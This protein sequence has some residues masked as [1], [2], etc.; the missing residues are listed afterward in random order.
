MKLSR[1]MAFPVLVLLA[2]AVPAAAGATPVTFACDMRIELSFERFTPGVDTLV[3]RGAFNGWSGN[4]LVMTDVDGDDV[5]EI[6][7]DL[8]A[9]SHP[10]KF[11]IPLSTYDRWE[12]F[13]DNRVVTVGGDPVEVAPVFFD[14]RAGWTPG[15]TKCGADISF[16]HQIEAA[17][18]EYRV[19]GVPVNLFEACADHGYEI[20]RLRLWHTPT[21]PWHALPATILMAQ[22][23]KAAGLQFMLDFHYSDTWADPGKQFKPAAWEGIPFAA[24]VDSV[25]AYT[26]A[27]IR[28][29]RDAGA[30]PDY[31]QIGNEV[32]NGMLWD[33]GRVGGAWDTPTQWDNFAALLSAGVA[34]VQDSLSP[35]EQPVIIIHNDQGAGVGTCEWFYDNLVSRGVSF[36]CIG[37]SFYP[38][39]HGDI[40]GLRDNL[41]NLAPRYG[42]EI[43]VV[44][45]A[46]PWTLDW[47]DATNNF[48]WQESQLHANYP[49]TQ[50]GQFGFLR[51]VVAVVEATPGG[52]G[53]GVLYWEPGF[54][55]VDGGPGSPYEN[56]TTFDFDG[57]A[58]PGFGFPMPWSTGVESGDDGPAADDIGDAGEGPG[59]RVMLS[60]AAPN[61]FR[62]SST[63]TLTVFAPGA[64][65]RVR[66]YDVSGRIVTTLTDRE[67][68]PG[69]HDLTWDG[70][71]TSGARVAS[72]V[73]LIGATVAGERATARLVHLK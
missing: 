63:L 42:K 13:V 20:I 48:V 8:A 4:G 55:A 34:G 66:V 52:L 53:T 43:M 37:L 59:S 18:G 44:E 71:D 26:N 22:E 41:E 61:P 27:A 31:V 32:S 25:Y 64:H 60:P 19:D 51:D 23:T 29:F 69:R 15:T 70:R 14:H 68:A 45:T 17:G 16:T 56:L 36:D 54:I 49:A 47:Y 2:L 62:G 12:H 3:V 5:Y 35:A 1:S 57:D 9:G 30:L 38:W 73:Y 40:W 28:A 46:Y 24:M 58:L 11:V 67:L 10:Y 39:W 6:T 21:D 72:G 65:A 50:D 7:L 33:D